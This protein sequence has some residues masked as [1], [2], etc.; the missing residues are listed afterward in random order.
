MV[1]QEMNAKPCV[2]S[3]AKIVLVTH[4]RNVLYVWTTQFGVITVNAYVN[5][6]GLVVHVKSTQETVIPNVILLQ[7]ATDQLP[8][9]VNSVYLM[10]LNK[11]MEDVNVTLVGV[12]V[13]AQNTY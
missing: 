10:L 9:S 8:T 3:T 5:L 13:I 12:V 6:T 1:S 4:L 11:M 2:L 7:D